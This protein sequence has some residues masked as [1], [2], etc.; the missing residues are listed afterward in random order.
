VRSLVS[1]Q[2]RA[3]V[4]ELVLLPGL[5]ALGYLLPTVLACTSWTRVQVL[6]LPGFGSLR[7]AGLP[8]DLSSVAGVAAAWLEEVPTRPVL[9]LGHSTG[10]Q[11]AL[12]AAVDRPGAVALLVLAGVTFDPE[13]RDLRVLLRRVLETVRHE[14]PGELSA[15]LPY[16]LRGARGLPALLGSSLGDR[17]EDVIGLVDSPV[18]VLRGAYDA[19]CP[20]CWARSLAD[21]ARSGRALQLPGAHNVP[22]THAALL[23]AVLA[24]AAGRLSPA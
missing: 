14:R 5:G 13:A 15:V 18:L 6:D 9:L 19:L 1:G 16:Y 12:R 8:A 3:G 24:E 22:Y 20:A 23:S 4:P 10:A 21:G 2:P 7:T 11:V 17:P